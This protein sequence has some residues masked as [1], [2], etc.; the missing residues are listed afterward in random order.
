[1]EA[2]L[3]GLLKRGAHAYG[4]D[5]SPVSIQ[6]A[7]SEA[8]RKGLDDRVTFRVMDAE[9]TEF[10]S[11]YFDFAVVNGVLAPSSRS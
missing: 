5:I 4:I 6:D 8:V 3:S 7:T 1:M 2:F 9:A 10:T 11:D